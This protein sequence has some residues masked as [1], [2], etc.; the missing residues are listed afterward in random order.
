MLPAYGRAGNA[1]VRHPPAM[2]GS[3]CASCFREPHRVERADAFD[4]SSA[5]R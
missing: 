4:D 2:Q 5:V 1:L 3:T